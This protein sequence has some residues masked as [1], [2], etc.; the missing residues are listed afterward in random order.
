[1]I[2]QIVKR[3]A[4]LTDPN[5][6]YFD[7]IFFPA[8]LLDPK[9]VLCLSDCQTSSAIK[10]IES[11]IQ[12]VENTEE[13]KTNNSNNNTSFS[14]V[15]NLIFSALQSSDNIKNSE[16][17]DE[18]NSYLD[19]LKKQFLKDFN[20]ELSYFGN[21]SKE[22]NSKLSTLEFWNNRII[23]NKFPLIS[24]IS[25]EIAVIPATQASSEEFLVFQVIVLMVN[26]IH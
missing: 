10:Y 5:A 4:S 23:I 1:M 14:R 22:N 25:C 9:F 20:L 16:V 26:L 3:F 24:K 2:E 11:L 12:T 21:S 19:Y 18:M 8:T 15:Q 6:A 17:S 7:P 13:E